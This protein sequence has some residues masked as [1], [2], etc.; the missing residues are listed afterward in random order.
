MS[1]LRAPGEP[2]RYMPAMDHICGLDGGDNDS[3]VCGKRA[4]FHLFAGDP[5]T[6]PTDWTMFACLEHFGQAQQLAWD[7]HEVTAVCDIPGTIWQ[8]KGVQGQGFCY[9]PEAETAIREAVS[10]MTVEAKQ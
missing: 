10:E 1:E 3:P 2:G 6:G 4:D 8:P 5:L 7:Y 9:W